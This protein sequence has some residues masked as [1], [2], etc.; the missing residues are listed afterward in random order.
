MANTAP[1]FLEK[2]RRDWG[3]AFRAVRML[4][5]DP[6]DTIQVFRI[7]AALNAGTAEKNYQRLI[8]TGQGGRIAYARVELVD[9][10]TN[11]EWLAQFAPGTVG[12]AY[13]SFLERTGFSADGLADISN[14]ENRR[15]AD[16]QHPYAWFG[17]RERDLHDIWHTLTGYK[18]EEP[19]GELCLVAF[20]YAQTGGLG[21]GFI[22]LMGA[23]KS[24]GEPHGS[25]VRRAVWEGYRHGRSASWLHN[26]DI[27]ALFAE[28]IEAARARLNIARAIR[29]EE[30]DA[31]TREQAGEGAAVAV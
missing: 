14:A 24:F 2:P 12:A 3:A 22:A 29:Y 8:K 11:R 18:A 9:W 13:R 25:A 20:S 23:L 4:L 16:L 15:P 17:R 31:L 26:E 1:T 7:M 28:P 30:A 5:A 19:L 21:W 6:A 27:A 10:L